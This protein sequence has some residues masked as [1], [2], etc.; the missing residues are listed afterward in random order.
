MNKDTLLTFKY[1]DS[2]ILELNVD[3]SNFQKRLIASFPEIESDIRSSAIKKN[4]SCTQK[5][6]DYV[7]SNLEKTVSILLDCYN[8]GIVNFDLVQIEQKYK[9]EEI[10]GKVAKTSIKEWPN[11]LENLK[12]GNYEY[13]SFHLVKENDDV[14]VF[15]S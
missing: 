6:I 3:N 10:S 5:V 9:K 4:C 11:F 1:I 15:F 14:Y 7:W 2:L 13:S 8:E 12:K